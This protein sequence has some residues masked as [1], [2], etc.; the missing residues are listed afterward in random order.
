M[1]HALGLVRGDTA[2]VVW[3]KCEG[4]LRVERVFNA[5]RAL[6]RLLSCVFAWTLLPGA[7]SFQKRVSSAPRP[8][9]CEVDRNCRDGGLGVTVGMRQLSKHKTCIKDSLCSALMDG[10]MQSQTVVALHVHLWSGQQRLWSPVPGPAF[11]C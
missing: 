9:V 11:L 5:K 4:R 1:V 7:P 3:V 6:V 10:Y 8:A 2:S